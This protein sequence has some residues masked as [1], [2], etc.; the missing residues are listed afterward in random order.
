MLI[1]TVSTTHTHTH[2]L[3]MKKPVSL[4]PDIDFYYEGGKMVLTAAYHRQRGYCC[5]S[6]CRH[7][8]YDAPVNCSKKKSG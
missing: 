6:G 2:T 3:I 1:A 5:G 8:P 4:Q 7:C